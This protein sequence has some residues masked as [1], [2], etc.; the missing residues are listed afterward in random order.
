MNWFDSPVFC[1]CT[2]TQC[3]DIHVQWFCRRDAWRE[4]LFL[5]GPNCLNC[6][7][8]HFIPLNE[9]YN[10]HPFCLV[11]S[12]L[13]FLLLLFHMETQR[14][15]S[16]ISLH[17]QARH[18]T[19]RKM[20]VSSGPKEV[21]SNIEISVGGILEATYPGQ[22]LRN[23]QQISNFKRHTPVSTG[24]KLSCQSK[25]N[26]LY[27]IMLQAHLD[28]GSKNFIRDVKAYIS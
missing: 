20:C 4:G 11:V 16:P 6:Y 17:F 9:S 1:S 27:S 28:E 19:L 8:F 2:Y 22:L 5:C 3:V 23:E 25:S 21:A 26:E 7:H 24:Q 13:D 12:H 15:H 18:W 10:P 14:R